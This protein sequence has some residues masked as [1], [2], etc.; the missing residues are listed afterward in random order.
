MTEQ[1]LKKLEERFPKTQMC[2]EQV[3]LNVPNNQRA[4]FAFSCLLIKALKI[5]TTL[6]SL[7]SYLRLFSVLCSCN[8]IYLFGISWSAFNFLCCYRWGPVTCSPIA[9]HFA[10]A[11]ETLPPHSFFLMLF[12]GRSGNNH[13]TD[14]W[15]LRLALKTLNLTIQK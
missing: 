6:V 2:V 3:L 5:T 8:K 9:V 12:Y 10:F 13:W 14:L 4:G 15:A 1:L 7:V 11:A